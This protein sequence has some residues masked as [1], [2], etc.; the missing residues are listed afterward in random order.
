MLQAER[1]AQFQCSPKHY[2]RNKKPT[3]LSWNPEQ[4]R[5]VISEFSKNND[6]FQNR[7]IYSRRILEISRFFFSI[8]VFFHEHSRIAG[9]QG[10]GEAIS[11]T[12][13]YQFHPLH[14]HLDISRVITAESSPL[15]IA[16]SRTRKGNLWFPSASRYESK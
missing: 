8:W 7:Q 12:P 4:V 13:N 2:L 10:K 5:A 3:F 16:S 14:R 11:L 9:L 6:L 15:H 1:H